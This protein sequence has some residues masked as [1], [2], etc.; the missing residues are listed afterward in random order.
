MLEKVAIKVPQIA[1]VGWDVAITEQGSVIIQENNDG[2]YVGYQLS[3]L[4]NSHG[5]KDVYQNLLL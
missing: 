3:E 4:C 2:E 5:L 1:Y